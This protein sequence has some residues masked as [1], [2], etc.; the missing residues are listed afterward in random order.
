MGFKAVLEFILNR[1]HLNHHK[2]RIVP[3]LDNYDTIFKSKTHDA[4]ISH[5]KHVCWSCSFEA[6]H[7]DASNEHPSRMFPVRIKKIAIGLKVIAIHVIVLSPSTLLS[8][9][10]N[11]LC[12][13]LS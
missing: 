11:E 12:M 4:F 6:S 8:L 10:I 7:R 3:N 1:D 2:S 9:H 13:S 5:G